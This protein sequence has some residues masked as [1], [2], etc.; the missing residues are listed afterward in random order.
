M[1]VLQR[2]TPLA[3]GEVHECL[4]LPTIRSLVANREVYDAPVRETTRLGRVHADLLLRDQ[5]RRDG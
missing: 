1:G 5:S 2:G 3:E 4:L